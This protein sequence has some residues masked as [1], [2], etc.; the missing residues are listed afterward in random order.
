M[1]ATMLAEWMQDALLALS[2][3]AVGLSLWLAFR[4]LVE[5]WQR[6]SW[7][8]VS[9]VGVNVG[10]AAVVALVAEALLR[11]PNVPLT[12]RSVAYAVGLLLMDVGIVGVLVD[13]GR[14][15]RRVTDR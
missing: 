11:L 9:F 15:D 3:I 12:W 8:G 14:R 13:Y 2:G 6:R 7:R 5:A 1:A 10:R 4:E